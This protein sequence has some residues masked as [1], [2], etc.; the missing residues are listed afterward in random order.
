VDHVREIARTAELLALINK[1]TSLT[2]DRLCGQVLD[3]KGSIRVFCRVR[4]LSA[5][6]AADGRRPCLSLSSETQV[7]LDANGRCGRGSAGCL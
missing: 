1:K 4:P 5:R 6:E 7:V 2:W 3:L